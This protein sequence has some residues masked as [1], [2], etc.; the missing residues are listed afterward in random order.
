MSKKY[1]QVQVD[2]ENFSLHPHVEKIFTSP[3]GL[4]KLFQ[5]SSKNILQVHVDLENFSLHPRSKNIFT[6]PRGL[7]KLFFAP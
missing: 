6:S 4:R 5:P 7:R 2:L 3:S 1:L